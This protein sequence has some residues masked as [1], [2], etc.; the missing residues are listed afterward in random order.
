MSARN[1]IAKRALSSITSAQQ[2]KFNRLD[3]TFG[4]RYG[5]PGRAANSGITATTFGA[6][7]FIGRYLLEELGMILCIVKLN[8]LLKTMFH[9][10]NLY[11]CMGWCY[12][13]HDAAIRQLRL[14]VLCAFPWLRIGSAPLEGPLRSRP[15]TLLMLTL[16]MLPPSPPPNASWR[17][18]FNPLFQYC[19]RYAAACIL[20][21]FFI[22]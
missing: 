3:A 13:A 7:G 10:P 2:K 12:N 9:R 22:Q 6:Y 11:A 21:L 20:L 5:P 16:L 15:G 19:S 1:L 14:A 18:C 8:T 17:G 4:V